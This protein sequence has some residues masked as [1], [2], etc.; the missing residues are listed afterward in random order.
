VR[1]SRWLH[2]E[3]R[4]DGHPLSFSARA[5]TAVAPIPASAWR[6]IGP[7]PW[8][9][10]LPIHEQ[11]FSPELNGGHGLR[12]RDWHDAGSDSWRSWA[13]A[14]EANPEDKWPIDLHRS[15]NGSSGLAYA[16]TIITSSRRQQVRLIADSGD[17]L[18]IW[19]NRKK[20]YS[21]NGFETDAA[22][23]G[24]ATVALLQGRNSVLVKCA[25]GGG[26]WGFSLAI[27]GQV[28]VSADNDPDVGMLAAL[29]S[30]W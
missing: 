23:E 12:W 26:G 3:I 15:L 25:S 4:I 27:D 6:V 1:A 8:D 18:E 21:Q 28:P 5:A 30:V 17:K 10:R 7:F 19:V 16:G 14:A 22:L 2:A 13:A 11:V 20:V 24:G 9:W 29:P